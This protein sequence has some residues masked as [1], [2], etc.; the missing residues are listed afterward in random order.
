MRFK[1]IPWKHTEIGTC[2]CC[3]CIYYQ[4][5]IVFGFLVPVLNKTCYYTILN[6]GNLTA[7]ERET[8]IYS[9]KKETTITHSSVKAKKTLLS[10][11]KENNYKH[12]ET[13]QSTP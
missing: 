10:T 3:C 8:E 7:R 13:D 12:T 2:Q 4:S 5:V 11:D 1:H 6:T 9:G